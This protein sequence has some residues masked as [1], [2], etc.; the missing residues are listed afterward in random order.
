[1]TLPLLGPGRADEL[2]TAPGI[3]CSVNE[4]RRTKTQFPV[5]IDNSP[6]MYLLTFENIS[7]MKM[8]EAEKRV[9]HLAHA[10]QATWDW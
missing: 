7:A 5:T 10:K 9:E 4:G 2:V 3:Q 8:A 1:L 6:S